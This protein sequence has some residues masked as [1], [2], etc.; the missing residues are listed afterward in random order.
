MNIATVPLKRRALVIAGQSPDSSDVELF[1]DGLPFLQG[2]AEFGVESPTPRYQCD[3]PKKICRPGDVLVSVRAPVGSVNTADQTYGIGRGLAA[4]RARGGDP[5]FLKWVLE[6][7][8]EQLQSIATG[9]TFEAI[10]ADD[11]ASLLV[12]AIGVV[13]ESLVANYLDRRTAKIDALI[14]KQCALIEKLLERRAAVIERA[15]QNDKWPIVP[16]SSISTL[17]QTGPFGSQISADDYVYN[18][19]SLINPAHM[20]DGVIVPAESVSVAE[21]TAQGLI[22]HRIKQGDIVVAR[23]GELGR[24]AVASAKDEG[25]LCGTGSLLI[26]VRQNLVDPNFFAMTFRSRRNADHLLQQSVGST[27][28]NINAAIVSRTR[29]PLPNIH[30]QREVLEQA[31]RQIA[32]IDALIVR[33]ERLI[34]LSE[35]RR[36]ALIAAAVYGQISVAKMESGKEAT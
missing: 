8:A 9:S 18:G 12:P 34:E 23:R 36:A 21:I 27:M 6:L 16:I 13:D 25:S 1:E 7:S 35:E 30:V 11:L 24:C 33:S 5:R 29:I 17:I 19:I 28:N 26:R 4:V 22:R 20:R 2:K 31:S 14:G 3:T 15:V 32:R 10:S